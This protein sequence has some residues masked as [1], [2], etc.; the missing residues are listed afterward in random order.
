MAVFTTDCTIKHFPDWHEWLAPLARLPNIYGL[1]IGTFEGRSSLWFLENILSHPTSHL[2]CIDQRILPLLRNNLAF[3]LESGRVTILEGLSFFVLCGLNKQLE[4]VQ[5]DFV[6]VD[7]GH[8]SA[9]ALSDCVLCFPLLKLGGIMIIDDYEWTD[10]PTE[11]QLPKTGIN[12]FMQAFAGRFDL[13]YTGYQICIRK[14]ADI[15]YT[16]W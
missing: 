3:H 5:Y 1:E 11:M 14:T 4:S 15:E 6:Y 8:T 2:T 7:G 10:M 9:N 16:N 13:I 12:A